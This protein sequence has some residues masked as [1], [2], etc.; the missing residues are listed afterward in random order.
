MGRARGTHGEKMYIG[1]IFVFLE[2]KHR[3]VSI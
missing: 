2:V 1:R 3:S